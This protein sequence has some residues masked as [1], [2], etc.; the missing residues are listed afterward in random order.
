MEL[1]EVSCVCAKLPCTQQELSYCGKAMTGSS[2]TCGK[3]AV[4][5]EIVCRVQAVL[6]DLILV[7]YQANNN[8]VF[9]GVLLDSTRR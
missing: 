1:F 2:R 4:N 9:Q 5:S 8:R 6:E 7:S 3:L